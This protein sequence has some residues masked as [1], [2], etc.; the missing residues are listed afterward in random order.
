MS[1]SENYFSVATAFACVPIPTEGNVC[2]FV[3]CS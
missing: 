1:I 2:G 3:L